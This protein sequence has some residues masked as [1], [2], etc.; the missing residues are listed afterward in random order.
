MTLRTYTFNNSVFFFFLNPTSLWQNIPKA[1]FLYENQ[2]TWNPR[3]EFPP[4]CLSPFFFWGRFCLD[5]Q[6]RSVQQGRDSPLILN[7]SF[8][9]SDLATTKGTPLFPEKHLSYL[10]P[11]EM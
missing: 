6:V 7:Y 3:K 2:V 8:P 9:P 11:R 1:L 4:P 5:E 10:L